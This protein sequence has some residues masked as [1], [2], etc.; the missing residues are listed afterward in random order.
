LPSHD[1]KNNFTPTLTEMINY[2][3]T[4]NAVLETGGVMVGDEITI[5]CEIQLTQQSES[6]INLSI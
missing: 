2:Y 1:K 6:Q 5:K 4:W 3:E